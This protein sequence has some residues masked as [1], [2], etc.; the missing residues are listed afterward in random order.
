MSDVLNPDNMKNLALAALYI[1]AVVSFVSDSK[2]TLGVLKDTKRTFGEIVSS[3]EY[4]SV[5]K[6]HSDA[7]MAFNKSRGLLVAYFVTVDPSKADVVTQVGEEL[8]RCIEQVSIPFHDPSIIAQA[9]GQNSNLN[10]A[11]ASQMVREICALSA[12]IAVDPEKTA[13]ALEILTEAVRVG[14][15]G[16]ESL[17][18][19][20]CLAILNQLPIKFDESIQKDGDLTRAKVDMVQEVVQG[21]FESIGSELKAIKNIASLTEKL[22][23]LGLTSEDQLIWI[24]NHVRA[25]K[26]EKFD[27]EAENQSL[28]NQTDVEKIVHK[29][30]SA[31]QEEPSEASNLIEDFLAE[32]QLKPLSEKQSNFGEVCQLY[33]RAIRFR[34]IQLD[35]EI[36]VRLTMDV[37]SLV[38]PMFESPARFLDQR[39]KLALE[40]GRSHGDMASFKLAIALFQINEKVY[41]RQSTP[42]DWA[43]IQQSLGSSYLSL[44]EREVSV[45]NIKQAIAAFDRALEIFTCQ[46]N[47]LEW[48]NANLGK[49]LTLRVLGERENRDETLIESCK[50]SDQAQAVYAAMRVPREWAKCWI[51]I[52]QAC[53]LLG[54]LSISKQLNEKSAMQFGNSEEACMLVIGHILPSELPEEWATAQQCLGDILSIRGR[55]SRNLDTLRASIFSYEQAELEFS[56]KRAPDKWARIKTNMANTYTIFGYILNDLGQFDKAL[57]YFK[58]V[59]SAYDA[60]L[61]VFTFER[62][63]LGWTFATLNKAIVNLEIARR[64]N[65]IDL[66][67]SAEADLLMGNG[68][69]VAAKHQPQIERYRIGLERAAEVLEELEGQIAE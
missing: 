56:F 26:A 20:L 21:G 67:Q 13:I 68:V 69:V 36:A 53:R 7:E 57:E 37:A 35:I 43:Q 64:R 41:Q 31:F 50:V 46:R 33:D 24:E 2:T 17:G 30:T 12:I 4:K 8:N 9:V 62:H 14:I 52:A 16:S 5:F 1:G 39:G 32:W 58:K 48:A 6:Q 23:G 15:S 44:G 55:L 34:T 3:N 25:I 49:A 19:E 29:V 40:Y 10:R 45:A 61:K 42:F 28:R 22:G 47:P 65:D 51:N 27:L 38:V 54:D 60:S 63:R 11:I 66:A 59:I 18:R